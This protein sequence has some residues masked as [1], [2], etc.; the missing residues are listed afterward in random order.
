MKCDIHSLSDLLLHS[1]RES[2][3]RFLRVVELLTIVKADLDIFIN[4][5]YNPILCVC[6]LRHWFFVCSSV[7]GAVRKLYLLQ[8]Q[9]QNFIVLIISR[10][11][12]MTSMITMLKAG[13]DQLLL[14]F[15]QCWE[16][17]TLFTT[18]HL[19]DLVPIFLR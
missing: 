4:F 19:A 2:L 3:S 6:F 13:C 18:I 11:Q 8:S 12:C 16:I 7:H 9:K 10:R 17:V 5:R 14:M 15:H 1:T